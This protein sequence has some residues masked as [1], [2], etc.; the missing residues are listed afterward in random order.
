MGKKSLTTELDAFDVISHVSLFLV[1][2][3]SE[4]QRKQ[5]TGRSSDRGFKKEKYDKSIKRPS[6]RNS[7]KTNRTESTVEYSGA[8]ESASLHPSWQASQARKQQIA[9]REFQGKR[10]KFDDSD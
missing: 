3:N 1:P 7:G 9:I 2:A 8:V 10:I 6:N 4:Q 5:N